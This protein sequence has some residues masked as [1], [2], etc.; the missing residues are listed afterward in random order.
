MSTATAPPIPWTG[1]IPIPPP[2]ALPT[3]GGAYALCLTLAQPVR[4]SIT[5][6]GRPLLQAGTYVYC[7]SAY[8]PGGL[9]ARLARH[10]RRDKRPHWHVDHLLAAATVVDVVAVPGGNECELVAQI[11]ALPGSAFPVPGFGSSDCRRCRAHLLKVAVDFTWPTALT[12]APL[13]LRQA[14][15]GDADAIAAV[16]SPSF[17]LLDFLPALHTVEEDRTFI[18]DVILPACDVL[19]VEH[20]GAIVGFLARD[21]NEIRLLYVHPG[22]LRRGAGSLLLEAAKASGV[23]ELELWCFQAN[24]RARRFYERHGFKAIA[25]TDGRDNEEETPDV[26]YRWRRGGSQV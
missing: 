24:A 21:G 18:A 8:G 4:L 16:F 19:V 11:A 22:F 10:L 5:R 15:P 14:T 2:E 9:R 7:G 13:T 17:R 6:L 23:D 25:F 12:N 3:A 20:E 1:T 26:R